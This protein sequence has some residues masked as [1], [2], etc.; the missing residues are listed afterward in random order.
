MD[1]KEHLFLRTWKVLVSLQD[2]PN[3]KLE[4]LKNE[5]LTYKI[6]RGNQ[7]KVAR[8]ESRGTS[9]RKKNEDERQRTLR[10][11]NHPNEA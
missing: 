2:W 1:A 4:R 11:G 3:L 5:M 10:K 7:S 6:T 9:E 8:K